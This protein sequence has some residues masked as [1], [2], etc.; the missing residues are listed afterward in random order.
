MKCLLLEGSEYLEFSGHGV[1]EVNVV[2]A[3]SFDIFKVK[4]AKYLKDRGIEVCGERAQKKRP[5]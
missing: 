3:R 4:I 1:V 2:D 5:A